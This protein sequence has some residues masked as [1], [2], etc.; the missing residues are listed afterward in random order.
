VGESGSRGGG[1][2]SL[3]PAF[4]SRG[5]V[6]VKQHLLHAAKLDLEHLDP[7]RLPLVGVHLVHIP[8]RTKEMLNSSFS[9]PMNT[10]MPGWQEAC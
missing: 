3:G 1:G 2:G 6:Q 10:R 4:V 7:V 8:L 5:G 9:R